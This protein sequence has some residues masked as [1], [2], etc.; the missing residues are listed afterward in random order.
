M[1]AALLTMLSL[2][3]FGIQSL[4]I[5]AQKAPLRF[6]IVTYNCEGMNISWL[7]AMP[8]LPV[9]LLPGCNSLESKGVSVKNGC[10]ESHGYLEAVIAHYDGLENLA[11]VLFFTHAH[12]NSW[13]YTS[14]IDQQIRRVM[15]DEK[16]LRSTVFGGLYCGRFNTVLAT[17]D[18][19]PSARLD[20][21]ELWNGVYNGTDISFPEGQIQYPCCGTFWVHTRAIKRRPKQLYERV[22]AN[23]LAQSDWMNK[24]HVCGR[25]GEESWHI[26]FGGDQVVPRP[27]FC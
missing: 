20:P 21:R 25:V 26:L 4:R 2:R 17:T 7:G 14:P 3:L 19:P 12:R 5:S 18:W 10:T 6:G 13:H 11:D 15:A 8:G 22:L 24:E 16:Y 23:T 27:S 9:I 1:L